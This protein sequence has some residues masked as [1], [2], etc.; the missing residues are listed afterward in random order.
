MCH[1]VCNF[2]LEIR[3]VVSLLSLFQLKTYLLD[4]S[5]ITINISIRMFFVTTLSEGIPLIHPTYK[6]DGLVLLPT[7][8][9]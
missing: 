1:V 8:L 2:S 3:R 7:H 5:I 4:I 6:L 9:K